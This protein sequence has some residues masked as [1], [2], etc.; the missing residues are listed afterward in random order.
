M[1]DPT[2]ISYVV[3]QQHVGANPWRTTFT[4]EHQYEPEMARH[5]LVL[6]DGWPYGANGD[7]VAYTQPAELALFDG[8]RK[9]LWIGYSDYFGERVV[10][11]AV[12]ERWRGGE[13]G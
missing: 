3:Q 12:L 7:W 2:R 9:R 4:I 10:E 11:A 13:Q 6:G 1:A 5:R 8:T